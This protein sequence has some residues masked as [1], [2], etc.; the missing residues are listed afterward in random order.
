MSLSKRNLYENRLVIPEIVAQNYIQFPEGRV[1]S[2][3]IPFFS[4]MLGLL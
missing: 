2:M 4:L 3:L 1:F